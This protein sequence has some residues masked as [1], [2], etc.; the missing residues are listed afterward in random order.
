[1]PMDGNI[2]ELLNDKHKKLEQFLEFMSHISFEESEEEVDKITKY[3]E[4]KQR[5]IDDLL[6]IE[7]KIKDC[8]GYSRSNK[9][10][11][12][13][14]DSNNVLIN[15]IIALDKKNLRVMNNIHEELKK[16][17]KSTKVK[18]RFNTIYNNFTFASSGS[19]FDTK[20]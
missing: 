1:M 2:T 19:R 13:L 18:K 17:L 12:L 9:D 6:K 5:Y 14:I 4:D 3:I 10:V 20:N 11:S 16:N 7:D 8:P 15:D